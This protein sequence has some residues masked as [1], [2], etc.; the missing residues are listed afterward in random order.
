MSD[1]LPDGSPRPEPGRGDASAAAAERGGRA[2][3]DPAFADASGAA[4]HDPNR[5]SGSRRAPRVRV[6]R[7]RSVQESLGSI[8]LGFEFIVMFLATLVVFGLHKLPPL[9]ALG[10]GGLLTVLLLAIIPLLKRPSGFVIGWVLQAII[11]ASS[12]FVPQ[13]LIVAIPFGGMWAYCMIRGSRIDRENRALAAARDA[14]DPP[15]TPDSL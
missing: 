8:V 13:M 1:Q 5:A 9:V 7:Q 12:I 14:Q 6:R 10:G 3:A 15:S 11:L 4:S 2:A